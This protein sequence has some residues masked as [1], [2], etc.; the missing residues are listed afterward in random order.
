MEWVVNATPRPLYPRESPGTHCIGGR[1]DPS[2]GLDGFENSRLHR[3]SIPG[4]SSPWRV[5]ILTELSRPTLIY[6]IISKVTS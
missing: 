2:A 5:A 3:D 6:C 1:V 4:P